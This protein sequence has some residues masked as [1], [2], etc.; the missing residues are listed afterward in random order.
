MIMCVEES[1]QFRRSTSLAKVLTFR[2]DLYVHLCL[3]G[4]GHPET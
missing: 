2:T 1:V 3:G 4:Y